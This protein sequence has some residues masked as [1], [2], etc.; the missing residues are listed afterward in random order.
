MLPDA[1]LCGSE[2]GEHTKEIKPLISEYTEGML[3]P[4]SPPLA[5]A[6]RADVSLTV[7]WL[8]LSDDLSVGDAEELLRDAGSDGFIDFDLDK[9][10][11]LLASSGLPET[12][13]SSEIR[14]S[15]SPDP[16]KLV[17]SDSLLYCGKLAFLSA[18]ALPHPL[19]HLRPLPIH[20]RVGRE[21]AREGL[22]VHG[23]RLPSST[24]GEH[25]GGSDPTHFFRAACSR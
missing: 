1:T 20:P 10:E 24:R 12:S 19:S 18:H 7:G 21:A 11:S 17:A 6:Q 4:I 15:L 3:R 9:A 14:L 22:H 5:N 25:D 23:V 2:A 16:N 13:S 8:G